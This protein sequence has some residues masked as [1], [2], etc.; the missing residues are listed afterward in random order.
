[1]PWCPDVEG[2]PYEV[3]A[4]MATMMAGKNRGSWFIPDVTDEVLVCFE[5]GD[6]RRPYV[7]GMLWNGEDTPS[8][9]MDGDGK[10]NIKSIKSRSGV[11]IAMDDTDSKVKLTIE[12]PGKQSILLQDEEDGSIQ[13][14]DANGNTIVMDKN[15]TIVTDKN[16]NSITM[17]SSGIEAKDANGNS[18]TMDSSGVVIKDSMGDTLNLGNGAEL[19]DS[20]GNSLKLSA[21]GVVL[22]DAMGSSLKM[23]PTGVSLADSTGNSLKLEI[24]G[25]TLQNTSG[26]SVKLEFAGLTLMSSLKLSLQAALQIDAMATQVSLTAAQLQCVSAIALFAGVIQSPT[27]M[28]AS[29]VSGAYTPG[30]GNML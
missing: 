11:Y 12:T 8:E 3:W 7:I 15:G 16:S 27:I 28:G 21:T 2:T 5:A 9:T 25:V 23:A 24:P 20:A 10:N 6:P 29:I 1:L 19:K 4:R 26:N 13:I 18:I 22:K 14:T 17:S 30:G